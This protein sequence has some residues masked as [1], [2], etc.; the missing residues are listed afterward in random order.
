MNTLGML[1]K[2]IR[3]AHKYSLND[4]YKATGIHDSTL[5]RIE[6]GTTT[7]P[8]AR[9]LKKLASF[10]QT[11]VIPLYLAC[12]YLEEDDL[13]SFQRCF[14]GVELLS[15]EEIDLIQ[16]QIELYVKNRRGTNHAV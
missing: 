4:V 11:D 6:N 8:P 12:G 1:L 9:Q 16:A 15:S 2:S 7:E 10:Y 14:P 5:S 13:S 3:D